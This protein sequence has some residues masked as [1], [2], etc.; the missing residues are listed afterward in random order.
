[1]LEILLGMLPVL[2][3]DAPKAYALYKQYEPEVASLV[4]Q[5]GP[6][7]QSTVVPL[8]EKS[9]NDGTIEQDIKG[10]I[11]EGTRLF[12]LIGGPIASLQDVV[13]ILSNVDIQGASPD[14][15]AMEHAQGSHSPGMSG[16]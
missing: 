7:I 12:N 2:L 11:D 6:M 1:M 14:S 4:Q 3:A 16:G 15:P 8:I 13:S 10:L 5:Y 9:I